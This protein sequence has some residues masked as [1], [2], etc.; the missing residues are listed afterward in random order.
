MSVRL[1]VLLVQSS[2]MSDLQS[3]TN[4]QLAVEMMGVPGIDVAIVASLK[5][6]EAPQTDRLLLSSLQNDLVVIDWRDP[7]EMQDALA[8]LGIH[9][10]RAPHRLDPSASRI[11]GGRRRLY[12][13]DLRRGD[14]PRAVVEAMQALLSERRVVAVPLMMPGAKPAVAPNTV[15]SAT[16][17]SAI[18]PASQP[19]CDAADLPLVTTGRRA[20]AATPSAAGDDHHRDK[21]EAPG[22]NHPGERD[23]D[24][25]VEGVNDLDW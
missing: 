5:A 12:L 19:A 15:A 9:G 24:A 6:D 7:D 14:S 17:A 21:A 25:L 11:A 4:A 8:E 3:A 13:V 22:G 16:A 18:D 1:N 10:A 2:G 20:A 23:L